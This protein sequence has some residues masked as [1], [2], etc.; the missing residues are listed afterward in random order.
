M[1]GFSGPG[2]TYDDLG[3][4]PAYGD[5]LEGTSAGVFTIL[6]QDRGTL[7]LTPRWPPC[8]PRGAPHQLRP[9]DHR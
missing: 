9:T 1:S 6:T 3:T 7:D 5:Y 2:F 4:R 8:K